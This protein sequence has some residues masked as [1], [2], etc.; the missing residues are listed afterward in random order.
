MRL[1]RLSGKRH[2]RSFDGGYGLHF[3]GR[4]NTIG[5]PVT[6]CATSPSLCVLEKLVHIQDPDLVPELVMVGYELPDSHVAKT[7]RLDELPAKWRQDE[8][9]TQEKGDAWL[10]AVSTPLVRVP[11]AIVPVA[12]SPDTNI[13]INH[14]HPDAAM[15]RI[16][17]A[18]P[19]V[20]DAR[21]YDRKREAPR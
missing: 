4:W 2:G 19:F 21:V 17:L 11:S 14:N 7:I 8:T 18:E 16:A 9:L 1:W 3:N 13:L 12:D 5:H 15:I 10:E 20:L 6:Y